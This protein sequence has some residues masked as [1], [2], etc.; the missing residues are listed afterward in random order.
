MEARPDGAG[1]GVGRTPVPGW[2]FF[3]ALTLLAAAVRALRVVGAFA[4]PYPDPAS[5]V[6][7]AAF[8]AAY[9][10]AL[11]EWAPSFTAVALVVAYVA[12]RRAGQ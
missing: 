1:R 9:L 3:V 4:G 7:S 10:R 2:R 12:R 6:F 11:A 5:A 8:G